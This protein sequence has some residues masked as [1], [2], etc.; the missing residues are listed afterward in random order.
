MLEW[1]LAVD[2]MVEAIV[3][4]AAAAGD[5]DNTAITRSPGA[6][7][8]PIGQAAST[9]LGGYRGVLR[10]R[11]GHR[12]RL[13]FDWQGELA[14]GGRLPNNNELVLY[15]LPMRWVDSS[16]DAVDR[17]VGLGTFDK[18]IFERLAYLQRLGVNAIEL[19]PV[20]DSTDTLN[21]GYGT[22]FLFAP[23]VDMGEPVDLKLFEPLEA[24][25]AGDP[26]VRPWGGM[27]ITESGGVSQPLPFG[28]GNRVELALH[29]FQVR[30]FAM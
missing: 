19:L 22:R 30:V 27:P 20:Q 25:P 16:S 1:L 14:A 12:Y 2:D 5:L 17:Q 4:A 8:T 15:E 13:P 24:L 6:G 26:C 11:D 23:D 28:T 9:R 29:P 7:S 21:W 3:D 10:M 18:A